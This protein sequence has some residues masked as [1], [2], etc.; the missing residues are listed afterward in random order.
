M[1]FFWGGGTWADATCPTALLFHQA[2]ASTHPFGKGRGVQLIHVPLEVQ[3]SPTLVWD[4]A[5]G[6]PNIRKKEIFLAGA[7]WPSVSVWH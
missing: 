5:V 7:D 3:N 2:P 4:G 6:K 1:F